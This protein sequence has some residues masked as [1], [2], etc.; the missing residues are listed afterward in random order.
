MARALDYVHS[1]WHHS[2]ADLQMSSDDFY[3]RV[4]AAVDKRKIP[5][6]TFSRVQFAEHGALSAK[7]E[8]L[9]VERQGLVFDV[10]TA[11]V[12]TGCF[13]SWWLVQP[14]PSVWIRLGLLLGSLVAMAILA[15][16]LSRLGFL[17]STIGAVAGVFLGLYGLVLAEVLREDWVLAVPGI[18][19]VYG[20]IFA[21]AT[22]YRLD[23][24]QMFQ[25]SVHSAFLEALE[26][27]T[28]GKGVR[29]LTDLER[30]PVMRA[31]VGS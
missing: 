5:Q 28:E 21:P 19:W 11:P 31:L 26:E 2:Y 14:P 16:I 17:L 9:R 29:A 18:G 25:D 3:T 8:Y 12:G 15:W 7:R 27:T 10:C 22:Y 13:V 1:H 23:T 30:K 6:L 24:V 20:K 4:S